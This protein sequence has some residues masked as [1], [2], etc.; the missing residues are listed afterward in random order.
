[1]DFQ[2]FHIFRIVDVSRNGIHR[3]KCETIKILLKISHFLKLSS[4]IVYK[5]K[6]K[7]KSQVRH[8]AFP[9][10]FSHTHGPENVELIPNYCRTFIDGEIEN[11]QNI[12][13]LNRQK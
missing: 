9:F 5:Q 1:M 10:D 4:L 7:T 3:E 2:I 13:I 8:L 12:Y 6:V 11:F